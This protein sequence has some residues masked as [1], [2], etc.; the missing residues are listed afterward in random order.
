MIK[1]IQWNN[2]AMKLLDQTRLPHEEVWLRLEH[3]REVAEAIQA[4]R[5][6][7]A[8]AIG[9]AAAYGLVLSVWHLPQDTDP[10]PV[11]R[12][13]VEGLRA[14]RPTAV[15]LAWAIS[16]MERVF[17]RHAAAPLSELQRA[18]LDEAERIHREDIEASQR[19]GTLGAELLPQGAKVL[20]ICNTGALATGGYG[21]ALGVVRAA[22]EQGRLDLVYVCETRPRLQGARLTAWELLREGIPHVLIVDAAAGF[23]MARGKVDA[24]LVGADRIARN[25]D[26]ANKI[27]TYALAVLAQRHGIPFYVVAPT[28]TVDLS[29]PNGEGIPIEEREETEV[30]VPYGCR[31]A[32]EGARAWNPA[33]DVTPGELISAIVTEMGVIT[34]P[35]HETLP[36]ALA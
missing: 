36:A 27:G 9:I 17:Q 15:N 14:T 24:V 18:L 25:G 1:P 31:L 33:F 29:L 6:R 5:V 23:L 19:M 32:P 35:Y 3:W 20:T 22:W 4:M 2:G 21:T 34:P 11:F 16:R 12:E 30:L 8:P 10:E 7:G 28:S 13:A 26:T